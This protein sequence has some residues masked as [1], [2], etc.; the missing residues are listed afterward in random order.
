MRRAAAVAAAA[1]GAFAVLAASLGPT[2]VTPAAAEVV[3]A[4]VPAGEP[5][6]AVTVPE[7][8]QP[9]AE[10]QAARARVRVPRGFTATVPLGRGWR[11]AGDAVH[12]AGVG[13]AVARRAV[14]LAARQGRLAGRPAPAKPSGLIK[15]VTARSFG[16][17]ASEAFDGSLLAVEL[18]AAGDGGVARVRLNIKGIAA[19]FGGNYGS[20][21]GLK[22]FPL[23][24][25]DT[26]GPVWCDEGSWLD[27]KRR[28]GRLSA[29]VPLD[30]AGAGTRVV[31]AVVA[32]DSGPAGDYA[33]SP[34]NPAGSWSH[35]GSSGDFQYSLPVVVPPAIAGAAPSVALSYSS[36]AVD[37]RTLAANGQV[38][39][40][41]QGWD[42]SPGF[43]ERELVP[44][45]Q[46]GEKGSTD[47]CW[48]SPYKREP[49][50]FAARVS[51]GEVTSDLIEATGSDKLRV[52]DD[53]GWKVD[54]KKSGASNHTYMGDWFELTDRNGTKYRFGF[55]SGSTAWLPAVYSKKEK[56][57]EE[58]C[59]ER[60]RCDT[61]TRWYLD[62]VVDSNGN[63]TVYEYEQEKNWFQPAGPVEQR[64]DYTA[65]VYPSQISYGFYIPPG[66][67]EEEPTARV[68][69]DRIGRC[70]SATA[71]PG[72]DDAIC[73]KVKEDPQDY[74]DVPT[75]LVCFESIKEACSN[76]SPTFFERDRLNKIVTQTLS[77]GDNNIRRLQLKASFLA[78]KD[79]SGKELWLDWAQTIGLD[80]PD[81]STGKEDFHAVMLPNR[82]NPGKAPVLNKPRIA[83]VVNS[84]GGKVVVDYGL[85]DKCDDPH[86]RWDRNNDDCFPVWFNPDPDDPFSKPRFAVFNKYVVMGIAQVDTVGGSP[87][88]ETNYSYDK[89]AWAWRNDLLDLKRQ[90][91]DQWRGYREVTTKVVGSGGSSTTTFF[92]GMD[93][94][95]N[96]DGSSDDVSIT[97][98]DGKAYTDARWLTGRELQ[99]VS[100][101]DGKALFRGLVTY[102]HDRT[103]L[104]PSGEPR[105]ISVMSAQDR[106]VDERMTGSGWE[107]TTTNREFDKVGRVNRIREYGDPDVR[108]DNRCVRQRW[109]D[110]DANKVSNMLGFLIR[111][112]V[113]DGADCD[114]G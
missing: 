30:I 73:P 8:A 109:S 92:Q 82:R 42:Y 9:A 85:P 57:E 99:T 38:S 91:W 33:A 113:H 104:G 54:Y 68:V 16:R 46:D 14:R 59:D 75:D 5:L 88:V 39:W 90:T 94:D 89:A 43:I 31:V 100:R 15:L 44:C 56:K 4:V 61:A 103:S 86:D 106:T 67:K 3:P 50:T 51:M 36:A 77:G 60:A 1:G 114:S 55:T 18:D 35:G 112:T 45:R 48:K 19:A 95:H 13:R 71:H 65:A 40:I 47:V 29:A 96:R 53:A 6:P 62:R 7:A 24:A 23:C 25:T 93:K 81:L 87:T 2:V 102:W 70:E 11:R 80:G 21:L 22:A 72:G 83:S 12:V 107:R 37:G 78:P 101:D 49:R 58:L 52:A 69:F 17:P 79:E 10:V 110:A 32:G 27:S 74:P 84:L 105:H 76:H 26:T 20:R 97:G 63:T 64:F 108:A 41:G 34:L 111:S 28:K 66:K 98:F